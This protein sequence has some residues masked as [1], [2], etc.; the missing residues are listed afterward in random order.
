MFVLRSS[1]WCPLAK[2]C[3]ALAIVAAVLSVLASGPV[4]A[5]DGPLLSISE[6]DQADAD[7]APPSTIVLIRGTYFKASQPVEAF[8]RPIILG[9]E[10]RKIRLKNSDGLVLQLACADQNS[11]TIN[12]EQTPATLVASEN[13]ANQYELRVGNVGSVLPLGKLSI[14]TSQS[15][16]NVIAALEAR[17]SGNTTDE[18]RLAAAA[19]VDGP[20]LQAFFNEA[21]ERLGKFQLRGQWIGYS[22]GTNTRH[23]AGWLDFA[24]GS[25]W[26][27]VVHQDEALVS[28]ECRSEAL[29]SVWLPDRIATKAYSAEALELTR[30]VMAGDAAAAWE[31]FSPRYRESITQPKLKELSD[32]LRESYG[33]QLESLKVIASEFGNAD[34][35]SLL[36]PLDVVL[37]GK[38]D[39]QKTIVSRVRFTFSLDPERVPRGEL[40]SIYIFESWRTAFPKLFETSQ[41][42]L[43]ALQAKELPIRQA[44]DA[45]HLPKTVDHAAFYDALASIREV[46]GS[47]ADA[48]APEFDRWNVETAGDAARA[49]GPV[50][51]ELFLQ[52]HF[53]QQ[54]VVGV[55][56]TG[57]QLESTLP[58]VTQPNEFEATAKAFWFSFLSNDTQAAYAL[59]SDE[60]KQKVTADSFAI[61]AA[62][63]GSPAIEEYRSSNVELG[64]EFGSEIVCAYAFATLID[65]TSIT[66]RCRLRSTGDGEVQ[67]TG[68]DTLFTH[69]AKVAVT[70][71]SRQL[72]EWFLAGN[73]EPLLGLTPVESR[74]ELDI[75]VFTRFLQHLAKVVGEKGELQDL[76]LVHRY[77]HGRRTEVL[78]GTYAS[79]QTTTPFTIETRAGELSR[80]DF[81]NPG[82]R[83]FLP[84]DFLRTE[85][86]AKSRLFV[87]ALFA[88]PAQDDAFLRRVLDSDLGSEASLD[89][90]ANLRKSLLKRFGNVE[91][92]RITEIDLAKDQTEGTCTLVVSAAKGDFEI[93]L[94]FYWSAT[95]LRISAVEILRN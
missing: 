75:A 68:Y 18:M 19:S 40:A 95:A 22:S 44:V 72:A 24:E 80:F 16:T 1:A 33:E 70:D 6:A 67:V 10:T 71:A 32:G 50:A 58:A 45:S 91:S 60:L 86:E 36:R 89:E 2:T 90:I 87:E 5:N 43:T 55:S 30:L 53:N 11:L 35:D 46:L 83:D 93:Q 15:D 4:K 9:Q 47:N 85:I 17:L 14:E 63:S 39:T 48:A 12:L 81:R 69:A 8:T 41:A 20:C 7:Q 13:G 73:A 49:T 34:L 52:V 37:V 78:S 92:T 57:N 38:T 59:L 62:T 65:G 31:L 29:R 54:Q 21:A 27:E 56:L 3:S 94:V 88:Q 28:I 26:L 25:L 61:I 77:Q 82:V 74:H 66:L 79:D 51:R 64:P 42:L 76:Q 84:D 23:V